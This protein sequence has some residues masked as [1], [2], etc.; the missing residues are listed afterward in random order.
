[1]SKMNRLLAG[2]FDYIIPFD[3]LRISTDDSAHGAVIIQSAEK[4]T[5]N[6]VRAFA[7]NQLGGRWIMWTF[8]QENP[9][10]SIN[11]WNYMLKKVGEK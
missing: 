6:E 1:M 8:A 10:E 11:G 9:F 4:V 7:D 5:E 3:G 2:E